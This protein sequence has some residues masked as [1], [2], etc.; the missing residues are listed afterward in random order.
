[1][2]THTYLHTQDLLV[3]TMAWLDFDYIQRQRKAQEQMILQEV[4]AHFFSKVCF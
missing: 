4:N 3:Q 2:C 1:V